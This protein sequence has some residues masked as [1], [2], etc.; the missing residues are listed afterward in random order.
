VR[1]ARACEAWEDGLLAGLGVGSNLLHTHPARN[2]DVKESELGRRLNW[3][4]DED[5][6]GNEE[7]SLGGSSSETVPYLLYYSVDSRLRDNQRLHP[8]NRAP[9]GLSLNR[10]CL[11]SRESPTC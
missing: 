11:R 5:F 6:M 1:R 7:V 4:S 2:P 8:S 3:A 9:M 10:I